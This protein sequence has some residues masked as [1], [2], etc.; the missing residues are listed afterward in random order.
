MVKRSSK[1][2][3][4]EHRETYADCIWLCT[5][6]R[7]I[8][9][10]VLVQMHVMTMELGQILPWVPCLGAKVLRAPPVLGSLHPGC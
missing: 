7:Y 8:E 10:L 3:H 6:L 5:S 9:L 2:I 1:P 4:I